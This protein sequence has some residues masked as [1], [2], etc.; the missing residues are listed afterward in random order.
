MV[1]IPPILQVLLFL[2]ALRPRYKAIIELIA[3]KQKDISVA[4]I[5]YIVSC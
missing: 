2:R 5:D 3:T 1:S 4:T